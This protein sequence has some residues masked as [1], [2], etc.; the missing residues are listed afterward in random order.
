MGRGERENELD[1]RRMIADFE[2]MVGGIKPHQVYLSTGCPMCGEHSFGCAY[3]S[4][5]QPLDPEADRK[6]PLEGEHLHV[7]CGTCHYGWIE[8]T[9]K[10]QAEAD[11]GDIPE[12]AASVLVSTALA[13]YDELPPQEGSYYANHLAD[14]VPMQHRVDQPCI[15]CRV[16]MLLEQIQ[17]EVKG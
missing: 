3:C 15:L 6:C 13:L 14:T 9:K 2:R 5:K 8:R 16:R 11:A 4:G 17:Q 7:V 10:S 1:R 12:N